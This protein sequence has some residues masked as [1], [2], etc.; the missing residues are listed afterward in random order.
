MLTDRIEYL[1]QLY[2]SNTIT[3]IQKEE[4]VDWVIQSNDDQIRILLE[5]VWTNYEPDT[6]MPDDMSDKIIA[7]FFEPEIPQAKAEKI[8]PVI[9][10]R[11]HERKWWKI[12]AAAACITAFIIGAYFW[13]ATVK[14]NTVVKTNLQKHS[15]IND[16]APGGQKAL[17]TLADGSLI[18]LDSVSNGLL[19]QQG[20]ARIVKLPNGEIAYKTNGL[21]A[22]EMLYNT[23]STPIGGMYQLILPDGSKV[24]LNSA[25]SIRYPTEFAG[26]ERRV[27][28]TGEAYFEI[29]KNAAIPFIVKIN[30][31]AEVKVLGTHFNVNAYEDEAEIKTTL[32]EG[33]VKI[34]QGNNSGLLRPG[35][36]AQINKR[37]AIKLIYDADIEE[38]VAWKNGNFQFNSASLPAV[39]QQAA[40]WYNLE[41]E[42]QG[43]I[44][45]DKFTGKISRSVNLSSF[46]KWMEWSDV[47]FKL[48]GKRIIVL[49]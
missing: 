30:N 8:A 21:A 14:N 40:R 39:L 34:S 2:F 16:I 3:E 45:A 18:V 25:S 48:D 35:Q 46:L 49:P 24:W 4:L 20:N 33:A 6:K 42:Y 23:M 13:P 41:I 1:I 26:K 44:P 19:A 11:H 9:S 29:A 5:K 17:L 47:H 22:K 37:G 43:K 38:A 32:L 15:I 10:I 31:D 12:A 36:Q 27:Q 7:S 28:I